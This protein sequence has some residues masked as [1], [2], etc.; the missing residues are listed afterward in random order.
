MSESSTSWKRDAA[1]RTA[2]SAFQPW[3]SRTELAKQ[4]RQAASD[5][6]DANTVRLK[7]LRLEK[8]HADA[9]DAAANPAPATPRRAKPAATG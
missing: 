8:E 6:S 3:A 5:A 7:A 9:E 1:I 4:E 2:N